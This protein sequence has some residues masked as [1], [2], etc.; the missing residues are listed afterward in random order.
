MYCRYNKLY[1]PVFQFGYFRTVRRGRRSRRT[2]GG[3]APAPTTRGGGDQWAAPPAPSCRERER[4]PP[5]LEASFAFLLQQRKSM[6]AGNVSIFKSEVRLG[7][8]IVSG[9]WFQCPCS[10]NFH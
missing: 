8:Y 10:L 1:L 4:E 2:G 5:L 9:Y 3:R 7:C 6:L